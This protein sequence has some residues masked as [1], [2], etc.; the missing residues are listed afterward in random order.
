MYS[1]KHS[2]CQQCNGYAY[3][4]TVGRVN[5]KSGY[6]LEKALFHSDEL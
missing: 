6:S 4:H 1:V 5:I 2:R 3:D